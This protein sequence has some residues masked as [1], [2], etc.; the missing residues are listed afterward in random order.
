MPREL[1]FLAPERVEIREAPPPERAPA[2]LRLRALASGISQGT[3]LLLYRGEGPTPFDPSLD[4]PGAPTYPRRYGYAFVGEVAESPPGEL[5]AG[6]RV[7]A[8][9]PH[10]DAHCV[11][12]TAVRV[13]PS[14]IPTQRAVLAANLETALNVIWDGGVGL[15]DDVWIIGGGV[16]GL[17]AGH[18]AKRAG[19]RR[20]GLSE[21]SAGRRRAAL[22]LGFDH[23][24]APE[25]LP[26]ATADV[27]VEASGNPACLDAAI[28][29]SRE[30]G[31]IVVASFYGQRSA[32]VAL[33]AEF[34]RRRLTLRSSQVSRLPPGRSVR[35]SFDRRFAEVVE[36]LK[37]PALDALLEPAVPLEQAAAVYARLA[38]A[39]G[40]ALQTIFH[41]ARDARDQC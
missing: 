7:F 4:E 33:G 30:E 10:G 41:Y 40:E 37:N 20:V 14:E 28:R 26:S 2:Q 24:C 21:P 35:W 19:A 23:A 34:H 15:G 8:L 5:E 11:A 27:V 1:W 9:L 25:Q 3:E 29:L 31:T 13:L 39:P 6:T 16:V 36:L 17:L 18:L 32:A 38:R 12:A 22:A